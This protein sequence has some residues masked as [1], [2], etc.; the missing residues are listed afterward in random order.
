M[1]KDELRK[2]P[3]KNYIILGIVIIVTIL[4][5]YYLYMWLI[6]YN[7]TKL[8]K[9]ILDKY[10]NVI[11]YNELDDYLVENPNTIIYVSVLEN[12]EIRDFEIEFKNSLKNN[13][14]KYDLL[15]L[16]LTDELQDSKLSDDVKN[17]YLFNSLNLSD[18]PCIVVIQDGGLK[19]IYSL[20]D[21][22]YDVVR[23]VAFINDIEF[24][25]DD[26]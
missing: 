9:P 2:I 1:K 22:D 25:E 4:I 19:Y 5:L 6:A 8:N 20:K 21:N 10:M 14:V 23:L 18:V 12:Q 13:K 15:Y 3:T 7:E 24:E 11:N 26:D 17:K 16:D